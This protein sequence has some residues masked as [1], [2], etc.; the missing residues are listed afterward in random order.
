MKKLHGLMMAIVFLATATIA[1]A[2]IRHVPAEY[3]T[4]QAAINAA[5]NGDEVVI[6]P[7]TYT[8]AG[9]RDINPL[10]KAITI[11]SSDGADVTIIDCEGSEGSARRGFNITSG[12]SALVIEGLTIRNGWASDGGGIRIFGSAS[13]AIRECVF[14]NCTATS[15][16]G[17]LYVFG[18]GSPTIQS[19]S[20]V[21][22]GANNG[23]GVYLSG[24]GTPYVVD[25]SFNQNTAGFSGGGAYVTAGPASIAQCEFLGNN[26]GNNTG[27]IAFW[28]ATGAVDGCLIQGNTT[29]YHAGGLGI[30]EGSNVA[31]TDTIIEQN[32]AQAEAGGAMVRWGNA[33]ATFTDCAIRD[34]SLQAESSHGG[35]LAV[36]DTYGSPT[37]LTR[38]TIE[39]NTAQGMGGGV[40]V[41]YGNSA[42]TMTECVV[43]HN[44]SV[45]HGGGI[46]IQNVDGAPTSIILGSTISFNSGGQHGGGL[47]TEA[48]VTINDCQFVG[49][50]AGGG[51]AVAVHGSIG[52]LAAT[53][54]TFEQNI[55]E[56]DGGGIHLSLGAFANLE[57]TSLLNNVA[58]IGGGALCA[59]FSILLTVTD[60][61]FEGN[62]AGWAG[63]GIFALNNATLVIADSAFNENTA[64]HV[65]G[66][67]HA[68]NSLLTATN[69][70]FQANSVDLY[71]GGILLAWG[72]SAS[73]EGCDFLG[74]TA[75]H[76]GGAVR[77]SENADLTA[78]SCTFEGNTAS[79][80]GAM[81][82][83]GS[84]SVIL[85]ES[86]LQY[87][88]AASL[89]GGLS[90]S[91]G[92][93]AE[94]QDCL[95]FWN[96]A[97]H[98]AGAVWA[99]DSTLAA[100]NSDFMGNTAG[101]VAGAIRMAGSDVAFED[102][103]FEYNSAGVDGGAI[104][105]MASS[106]LTATR[107][108]FHGN[109]AQLAG[110]GIFARDHAPEESTHVTLVDCVVTE[111]TA[112]TFGG[113]VAGHGV[114]AESPTNFSFRNT[115]YAGNFASAD[116]ALS[117]Y[118]C[119]A[120]ATNCTIVQNA[121]FGG[122]AVR[123]SNAYASL[124]NLIVRNNT[125][126]NFLISGGTGGATYSNI[127]GG[128]SGA[129][130]IDVDPVFVD[131]AGGDYRLAEGSPCI[132]AGDNAY[133][134]NDYDLDGNPRIA[135]G[136]GDG[137]AVV[138]MGAYEF[139]PSQPDCPGDLN[140]DNVV[141]LSDLAQ[142]LAHYGMTA[143]A[144]YQDG[145]LDGD[146]DVDL[147]DLAALL[148]VYG[149]VCR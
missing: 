1:S 114:A 70:L 109:A 11:R 80:G 62:S 72:A 35:G 132:D 136:N 59:N 97:Q 91:G 16:G 76:D 18:T 138:D 106:V 144:A 30:Y 110:G 45:W 5:V 68:D 124:A 78:T 92:S 22:N 104:Y 34:N 2:A 50:T 142:L 8:G 96:T 63:G 9:N 134:V 74:N 65:G 135:D 149:T 121:S 81:H 128:W 40:V 54:T 129:G 130:N 13:P 95:V 57:H 107:S 10:G 46:A 119:S 93:S 56:V 90:L 48:S 61:T 55:A 47:A 52:V 12:A 103:R 87:N 27:A 122:T 36:W 67:V 31:I 44:Q 133:V 75:G 111:N 115:L 25:C 41:I 26:A 139:Q 28:N 94:L 120:D 82:V 83:G 84:S 20:F 51:G 7:G 125:P 86:S 38:C 89:G 14:E 127:Q 117:L 131:A 60:S 33:T 39:N 147:S 73:L 66:A 118:D 64:L 77:A 113:G 21:Q 101:V 19:C 140:G 99:A 79:N 116:G 49:N 42:I 126:S 3:S 53:N 32:V 71:G 145:D 100:S 85:N 15:S 4:I 108:V 69:T 43:Q 102:C 141:N 88:D 148:G 17:G 24:P 143:G 105:A 137:V 146:G 123:V 23:G 58:G 29:H 37:V 112:G 6:A 98:D